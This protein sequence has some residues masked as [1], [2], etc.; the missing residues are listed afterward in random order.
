MRQLPR[1]HCGLD[2]VEAG[3]VADELVVVLPP[4]AV[5]AQRPCPFGKAPVVRYESARVAER[6][7]VLRGVEAECRRV[8]LAAGSVVVA[9]GAVR[10]A[11]IFDDEET[12]PPRRPPNA[13]QAGTL[14]VEGTGESDLWARA[15]DI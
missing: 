11:R 14:A 6:P 9:G 13:G 12:V 10:L 15:Y 5:L 7:Q 2:G 8:A 1:K 3:R 4:L